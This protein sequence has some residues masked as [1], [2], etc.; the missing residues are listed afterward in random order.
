MVE[1]QRRIAQDK[2]VVC[3]GRDIGTVVFP[4]ADVKI[5]MMASLEE[6]ARRRQKE[7]NEKKISSRIE[8]V[9]ENLAFRDEY[10]TQREHSPLRV[11]EGAVIIDTTN[12][13]IEE[14]I[15]LALKEVQK[16]LPAEK[17]RQ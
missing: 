1:Q 15:E 7:L 2:C 17:V 8:E 13:S 3:E 9:K 10:D 16:R 6:R 4:D 11:A 12:L 14:E 5:F